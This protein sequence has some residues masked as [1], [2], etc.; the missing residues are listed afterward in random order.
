MEF[1]HSFF[2]CLQLRN[3]W[4]ME[5]HSTIYTVFQKTAQCLMHRNC[6]TVLLAVFIYICQL[7]YF[8]F[9]FF[10]RI[11]LQNSCRNDFRRC[12]ERHD[13]LYYGNRFSLGM[14]AFKRFNDNY[15]LVPK[16]TTL[17]DLEQPIR[18]LLQ[19]RCV[20]RSSPQKKWMKIDPYYQRQKCRPLTP[21]S[22]DIRFMRIFAGFSGEGASNDSV[23]IE[24]VDF[25][26]FWTLVFGYLRKWGQHYYIVLFSPL[27]PFQ[28]PRNIWPWMTLT[29][30]LA[31]NSVFAPVCLAETVPCARAAV[32]C[33]KLRAS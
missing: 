21:V 2:D 18:I 14:R 19:K 23:V 1:C 30:Y 20:F 15:R 3:V 7:L 25:Q 8:C 22:G 11:W 33:W 26:G 31:L 4:I 10:F 5:T 28:W 29:G 6:T 17:D 24:N 9:L 13:L 12:F 16:S 32:T 27:S